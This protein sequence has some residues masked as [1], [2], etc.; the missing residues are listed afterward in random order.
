M[1]N[2][3]QAEHSKVLQPYAATAISGK[4]NMSTEQ[5]INEQI[6]AAG[7]LDPN[8]AAALLEM[9]DARLNGE[10]VLSAE[11]GN[12]PNTTQ[13][14]EVDPNKTALTEEQLNAENA[15]IVAKDGKHT[16]PFEK[17]AEARDEAKEWKQRFEAQQA[18]FAAMQQ[19]QGQQTQAEQNL[20]TAEAVIN[21]SGN[22][23]DVIALFGDFSET[24]IA[25]AV[26]TLIDQRLSGQVDA[27]VNQRLAEVNEQ[28]QTMTAQE[29]HFAAIAT[30]HPDWTSVVESSEFDSWMA[31]QPSYIQD[32]IN[33]VFQGGTAE[34]VNQVLSDYKAQNNLSVND[35]MASIKEVAKQAVNNARSPVPHSLSDLPAGSPSAVSQEERLNNMNGVQLLEAFESMTPEQIEAYTLRNA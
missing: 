5:E 30:A 15:V 14:P 23:A 28:Q 34:Q 17:L 22:D 26:Q 9:E 10:T 27:I 12:V 7:K 8:L 4:V 11:L 33:K 3:Q 19:Q 13:V 32:G 1:S 24:S 29:Q 25:N 31:K 21:A 20:Q 2:Q 6:E 16:I 35:P 18:Q